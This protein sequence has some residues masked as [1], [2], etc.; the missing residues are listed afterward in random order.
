MT[1]E[2]GALVRFAEGVWLHAHPVSFIGL[3]LTTTMAVLALPGGALLVYSPV[4]LTPEGR[5]EIEALGRV[6]HLYAPNVHH[7]RWLGD[8]AAAFPEARVHAPAEL[9]KK[10]PDLRV[11]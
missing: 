10:R 5:A 11:D 7:V 2:S 4:A 3:H 1:T 9:C 6:A 8:W